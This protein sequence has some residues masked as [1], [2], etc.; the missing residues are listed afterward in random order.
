MKSLLFTALLVT[1]VTIVA[2]QKY[3]NKYDGINLDEILTN[4]KV[5]T[6][7]VNCALDKGRCS[8]D[9]KELKSHIADALRTG[10]KKCTEAQKLGTQ[11][12]IRHLIKH[13]KEAWANLQ[14]K[15]DP[16]GIYAKKYERELKGI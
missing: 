13:E 11:K 1:A 9:G 10:C 12:V 5:L 7:Y 15:Y 14:K 8:V 16:V 3:T 2:A 4:K 6:G